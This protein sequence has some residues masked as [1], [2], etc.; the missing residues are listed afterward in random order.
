MR[1]QSPHGSCSHH[2]IVPFSSFICDIPLTRR[3]QHI[4]CTVSDF[5][6]F[7]FVYF[8]YILTAAYI[9][10]ATRRKPERNTVILRSLV[11]FNTPHS[12]GKTHYLSTVC[13][14]R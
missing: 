14:S 13:K 3:P 9:C 8:V 12:S 4:I 1:P 7:A 10:A 6:C 11:E 5:G 2:T